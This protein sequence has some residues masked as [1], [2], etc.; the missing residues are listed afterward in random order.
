MKTIYKNTAQRGAS[1]A[2]PSAI[3]GL[4]KLL[5]FP[6]AAIVWILG[7]LKSAGSYADIKVGKPIDLK[8]VGS[9]ADVVLH[10]WIEDDLDDYR[11]ELKKLRKKLSKGTNKKGKKLSKDKIRAIKEEIGELEYKIDN[12][13]RLHNKTAK[14]YY[15][16]A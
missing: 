14:A 6:I 11:K 4:Y 9:H 13:S 10:E 15:K 7:A 12:A 5:L 8:K 1:K 16:Y 2:N 3:R